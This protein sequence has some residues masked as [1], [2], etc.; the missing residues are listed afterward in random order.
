MKV[1]V[2]RRFDDRTQLLQHES[3]KEDSVAL[4]HALSHSL[5]LLEVDKK[6]GRWVLYRA[7][8]PFEVLINA[9]EVGLSF[10][11]T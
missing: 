11:F 8:N 6:T 10:P 9:F 5:T 4:G 7:Y 3:T 1:Y 2:T